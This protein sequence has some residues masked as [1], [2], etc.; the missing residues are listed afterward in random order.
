[1]LRLRR[2]DMKCGLFHAFVEIKEKTNGKHGLTNNMIIAM[3][4]VN[5]LRM[6]EVAVSCS[7]AV[8]SYNSATLLSMI[9]NMLRIRSDIPFKKIDQQALQ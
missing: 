5:L 2:E 7:A 6:R 8:F 9:Y 4:T 3:T 1:M